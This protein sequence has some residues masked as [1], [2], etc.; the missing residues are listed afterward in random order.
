MLTQHEKL[1]SA[2]K[3]WGRCYVVHASTKE[4]RRRR[5]HESDIMKCVF[6]Y[7]TNRAALLETPNVFQQKPGQ[8]TNTSVV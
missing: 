5:K 1:S 2:K 4:Q 8:H 7:E 6:S 3:W